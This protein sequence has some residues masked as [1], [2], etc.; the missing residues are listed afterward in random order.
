LE[1]G[2][3]CTCSVRHLPASWDPCLRACRTGRV[4]NPPKARILARQQMNRQRYFAARSDGKAHIRLLCGA[5]MPVPVVTTGTGTVS[6][7]EARHRLVDISLT[8]LN[9]RLIQAIHRSAKPPLLMPAIYGH[10]I[11]LARSSRL[12]RIAWASGRRLER[13]K[14]LEAL[15]VETRRACHLV[16]GFWHHHGGRSLRDQPLEPPG[17]SVG[18][19]G[20]WD[21]AI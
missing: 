6:T 18:R 15:P 19:P 13:W 9:I 16:P 4:Q 10:G 8:R 20:R 7:P 5:R 17:E 12:K 14:P 11:P 3:I 1:R 21:G 2:L